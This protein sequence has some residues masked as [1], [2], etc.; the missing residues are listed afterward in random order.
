MV[1]EA[2]S[3]YNSSQTHSAAKAWLRNFSCKIK[4][5]GDILDVFVQHHPEYV[6]LVWGAMKL[7]FTVSP[8]FHEEAN[9]LLDIVIYNS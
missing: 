3:K 2:R 7:L 6:S 1:V 4:I 5:Y 8:T 9:L